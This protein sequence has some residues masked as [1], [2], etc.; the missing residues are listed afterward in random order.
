[1]LLGGQVFPKTKDPEEMAALL[2]QKGFQ[3]AALPYG[4][5]PSMTQEI[6]AY[7]KAFESRG[8]VIAEVGAWSNPHHPDS[9][10][11]AYS[12][13]FMIDSLAVAEEAGARCCVNIIGSLGTGNNHPGNYSKDFY[14]SCVEI[15]R[16]VID[17]VNPK[18]AKMC[19][20]I[21]PFNFL[22]SPDSYIRF[23]TDVDRKA[24]GVHLDPFNMIHSPRQY[25]DSANE[26]ETAIRKLAP[27][28]IVSMHLK[29]LQQEYNTPNTQISERMVGKGEMDIAALFKAMNRYLPVDTPILIE[30][31]K[32]E[33]E[34][35][36]AAE[37][38]RRIAASV[39]LSFGR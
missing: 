35:T 28:G 1:M 33:E 32:T 7:R 12:M 36:E 14:D 15:A 30:H 20:E 11:A 23:I 29:D 8:L 13:Q 4:I 21:E 10:R 9:G 39:G 31:L 6:A 17:A 26:F 38:A 24:I 16:K 3:C 2:A 5:R 18:H 22:D 37:N 19:F 34:Y 25:Y 27:Y